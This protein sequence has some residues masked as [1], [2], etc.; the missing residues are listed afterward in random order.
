MKKLFYLLVFISV[1]GYSQTPITDANFQLAINNCL[2]TNPDDGLCSE[3]EYGAMPDW[4]VSIVTSMKFAFSNSN[5]FNGDVSSWD[6]SSVT[7]MGG[8]FNS[9]SSFNGDISS[10][11]VSSVTNMGYM[12][13]SASSFNGDIGSWDV[14]NVTNMGYMFN[15]ASTFNQDISSWD[16]SSVTDMGGMFNSA[17]SFNQDI[18]GWCVTN[19]LYIDD[20]FSFNSPLIESNKP[21][22]GICSTIDSGLLTNGDFE[23]GSDSWLV[24]VDDNTP[25]PVVTVGGNTYYSV[26]VTAAGNVYDVNTSQKVEIINGNTYTLTFD[27]W[28]NVDRTI[29]AGIGLSKDP[30]SNT[31][32]SVSITSTRTTYTLTHTATFG[33]TDA[34]V[35][36]DN[37]G[38]LGMVNIDNVSLINAPTYITD[39]N[40]R[41]AINTCL[42]TNPVDGMC[43]DSRYGA[44]PTWDVS[45]VTNMRDAFA[46]YIYFNSD[47]SSWDVSNVYTMQGMFY[48]ATSFNQPIGDWN[49]S[50]VMNMNG[51]FLYIPLYGSSN[52]EFNQDISNWNVSSVIDMNIMFRGATS[53]NGDIGSWDVSSVIYMGWMFNY[54]SSFNGDISSWDVSSVTDMGGMF[55]SASSFNGDISS[56]DVSSVSYMVEMFNSA[57]FFNGDIGSWDVSSVTNMG[58]MFN[59][60]SFFNGDIGSWDVSNV[61]NMGHMFNEA[62]SFNQDISSWCVSN[63]SSEPFKFSLYSLLSI[64]NKPVWGTCSSL[65]INDQ[66]LTNVSI[67]PNPV[68]DKLFI[69][70]LSSSSKVSI[71]NVLGKLVLSQT[72][73]K[74]IDVKQL[75][76]GIYILKIIDEQ[77]ETTRKFIKY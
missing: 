12:F 70:G 25:A 18:S 30:W 54:A 44:M 23:N 40:F 43:S 62:V 24:G 14:S 17:S 7:N 35:L 21:V 4:D 19:L 26:D 20:G 59:S 77:K 75:S 22:W 72:I 41:T 37:G 45:R 15:E 55:N 8:M 49:V 57:S 9:A 11:D 42:T 48:N 52:S 74:E 36:F 65:G 66:N 32:E 10:W 31:A 39:T 47:I 38:E 34:R 13:N 6:V 1:L 53:F 67:Y 71:Y 28:S 69:K 68:I 60:A 33:A 50:N 27:A 46:N 58:Y 76:K 29:L 2:S 56:W 61:T 63:I 73:S 16:V 51:M 3:S 5:D 64:S